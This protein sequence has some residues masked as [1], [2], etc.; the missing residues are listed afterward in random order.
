MAFMPPVSRSGW[1][2]RDGQWADATDLPFVR[3]DHAVLHAL[4]SA[5]GAGPAAGRR[6][7][8]IRTHVMLGDLVDASARQLDML[9]ADDGARQSAGRRRQTPLTASTVAMAAPLSASAHGSRPANMPV[10][11]SAIPA[12]P[13]LKIF[14]DVMNWKT[15]LKLTDLD[16]PA[17]AGGDLSPV[18]QDAL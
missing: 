7:R 1:L 18:R 14:G 6:C 3:D 17:G 15:D 9:L 5:L 11:R 2:Y 4:E 16:Q 10:A 8:V 12:F 13:A